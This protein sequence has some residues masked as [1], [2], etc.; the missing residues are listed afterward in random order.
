MS[1][2]YGALATG[3]ACKRETRTF[4]D[5]CLRPFV[6]LAYAPNLE[7]S[8]PGL[9]TIF[10]TFHL[11]NLSNLSLSRFINLTFLDLPMQYVRMF[12]YSLTSCYSM[13]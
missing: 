9:A 1:G 2:F 5:A 4:L 6:G 3:V 10:P 11:E 7:T 13:L 12:L 8:F